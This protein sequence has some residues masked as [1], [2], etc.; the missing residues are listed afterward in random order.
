VTTFK[1]PGTSICAGSTIDMQLLKD[2]FGYVAEAVDILEE[3]QEFK[4]II[5]AAR[6]KLAPMQI[7]KNGDVQEWLEDWPQRERSHRHISNLY[8][9]FPGNQISARRTPE[10]AEGSKVVLEQRGL[11]G[12]GWAS[13]WKMGCWARLYK[14]QKAM[15]N[16]NYTI[17]NYTF[18][19]LFSICSRALQVDG[20]FGI[21]A[22]LVEMLLQSH[23]NELYLLP[24][25][26]SSWKK[27]RIQGLRARGGFEISM[28]WDE[29]RL[30]EAVI[31][32]FGGNPCR[33]RTSQE[34]EVIFN[35]QS[36]EIQ[37]KDGTIQFDTVPGG[38]YILRPVRAAL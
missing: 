5:L 21:T 31:Q 22:A 3:D 8:G 30:T 36:V 20:T 24:A 1:S 9:L 23:E 7:G 26:H 34:V 15:D 13:A 14:P 32:S 17:H 35:G 19:N 18:Q 2:L 37:K 38:K 10:L 6:E 28:E 33:V 27:G 4:Q 12:N 29:G 11:P 25:R 16:F